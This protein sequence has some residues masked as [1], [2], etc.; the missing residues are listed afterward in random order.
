MQQHKCSRKHL[1]S[2]MDERDPVEERHTMIPSTSN[3]FVQRPCGLSIIRR[4]PVPEQ[5]LV[6]TLRHIGRKFVTDRPH[7]T[8]DSPVTRKQ[9][10][11]CDMNGLIGECLVSL[12][13]LTC[14]EKG[15]PTA[16]TQQRNNVRYFQAASVGKT[17]SAMGWMLRVLDSVACK[18]DPV[19]LLH[20]AEYFLHCADRRFQESNAW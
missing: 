7:R 4:F 9:H 20:Q 11:R 15:E 10:S 18:V 5:F 17:E 6:Y 16:R 1:K 12:C 8:N 19:C 13:C 14:G 2:Y 3:G